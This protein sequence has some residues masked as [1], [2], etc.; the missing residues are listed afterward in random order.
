MRPAPDRVAALETE[1]A[2]LR[3]ELAEI[4]E[5]SRRRDLLADDERVGV[6]PRVLHHVGEPVPAH[7][8]REPELARALDE[9]QAAE[10]DEQHFEEFLRGA[11]GVHRGSSATRGR[12]ACARARTG[13]GATGGGARPRRVRGGPDRAGGGA[14]RPWGARQSTPAC[15]PC[16]RASASASAA[17]TVRHRPTRT[18]KRPTSA[19]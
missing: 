15:A 4:E 19:A 3:A 5:R 12:G 11:I 10:V 13:G 14:S 17:S 1:L 18:T 2:A 8:E 9:L 6:R 16:Q 7:R